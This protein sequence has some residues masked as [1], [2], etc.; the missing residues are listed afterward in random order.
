MGEQQDTGRVTESN[1][2]DTPRRRK[3]SRRQAEA[4]D[5]AMVA[6]GQ[7][8]QKAVAAN[9]MSMDVN[10]VTLP[11]TIHGEP[12]TQQPVDNNVVSIMSNK[13]QE[14]AI[15]GILRQR[16]GKLPHGF[17]PGQQLQHA[18]SPLVYVRGPRAGVSPIMQATNGLSHGRNWE[19]ARQTVPTADQLQEVN[20]TQEGTLWKNNHVALPQFLR[21]DDV[22][23]AINTR[24]SHPHDFG[25]LLSRSAANPMGIAQAPEPGRWTLN[26]ASVSDSALHLDHSNYNARSSTQA[27]FEGK[28]LKPSKTP[29]SRYFVLTGEPTPSSLDTAV[30]A[31]SPV[32]CEIEE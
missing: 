27:I 22:L 4:T 2:L 29:P 15:E 14:T 16:A 20:S 18:F 6:E 11:D 8:P 25:H 19:N 24:A 23:P 1:I 21:S 28:A 17:I 12:S 3:R 13:E 5:I 30:S 32:V 10:S 9:F 26:N 31:I 7:A